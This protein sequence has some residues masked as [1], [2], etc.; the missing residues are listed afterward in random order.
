MVDPFIA[1]TYNLIMERGVRFYRVFT[2][3]DSSDAAISLASAT[4]HFQI[5]RSPSD[6]AALLELN[7]TDDAA[8][9]SV[10]GDDNNEIRIDLTA[11]Q[12]A[13]LSFT[14]GTYAIT[15]IANGETD[16]QGFIGGRITLEKGAFVTPV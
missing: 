5:R 4:V 6:S 13:A 7:S 16:T 15:Y 1:A 14:Q 9:V 12:T 2:Y 8:N 11:V 3:T 10:A